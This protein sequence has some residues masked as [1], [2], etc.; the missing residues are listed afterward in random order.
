MRNFEFLNGTFASNGLTHSH[1]G[2]KTKW[3]GLKR[4][5]IL[6]M[7]REGN[8]FVLTRT[9]HTHTCHRYRGSS[10]LTECMKWSKKNKQT[11]IPN[12]VR[13]SN[14][15]K[16]LFRCSHFTH[17]THS[18]IDFYVRLVFFIACRTQF[19]AAKKRNCKLVWMWANLFKIHTSIH[20]EYVCI[21]S[22]FLDTPKCFII[23]I[24]RLQCEL[25]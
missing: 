8:S 21:V 17:F 25:E 20:D 14:G 1:A 5:W 2:P 3:L 4:E 9:W 10:E 15:Y 7:N 12:N 19:I 11:H 23:S 18:F 13:I 24:K 6:D 16:L 22:L